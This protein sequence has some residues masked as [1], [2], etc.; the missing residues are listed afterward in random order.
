[1]ATVDVEGTNEGASYEFMVTVREGSTS[2]QHRVTLS[3][4]DYE[5]LSGGKAGPEALVQASFDFLLEREPKE[6]ILR[7]FELTT[8]S[9][10]FPGYE[11]E[12][13]GRL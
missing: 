5:R 10:Y 13:T 4:A 3:R 6:A 9:R 8:I 1:M 2:T 7:S 12:I 11:R